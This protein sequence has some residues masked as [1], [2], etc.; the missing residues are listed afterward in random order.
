MSNSVEPDETAHMSRLIWIY[1]VLQ[2]PIIIACDSERVNILQCFIQIM[3]C[4][5]EQSLLYWY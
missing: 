5:N 1:A 2:K 3:S 4:M